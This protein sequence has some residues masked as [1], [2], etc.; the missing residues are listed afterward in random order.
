MRSRLRKGFAVV[1]IIAV[2]LTLLAISLAAPVLSTSE[3]FS[4]FNSGWNGTSHLAITTYESGKFAPSFTIRST[5]TDLSVEQVALDRLALVPTT[6]S[7]IIIGPK[8]AFAASEGKA[9]G[10]FVRGGGVL[11]LADDFGSANSLLEGMNASSRFSH[12]LVIDLAYEKQPEFSVCFDFE[13]DTLTTNVTTL[14]MNYPS[15]LVLNSSAQ[16]LARS[17]LAS[18]RDTNGDRLQEWGEPRGPFPLL[19][20]ERLGSGTI[21]LLSDPSVL[22]NGMGKY[23]NN[24]LFGSNLMD[25]VCEDRSSVYFD[26]SHRDFFDPV[27]VTFE[28]TGQVSTPVKIAIVILM[29]ACALWISSDMIDRLV[30]WAWIK[31]KSLVY[32]LLRPFSLLFSRK[33]PSAPPL[34]QETLVK[35]IT[36]EH[37][38][39]RPGL[40]RYL[41]RE[42]GRHRDALQKARE[43]SGDNK[44]YP[45]QDHDHEEHKPSVDEDVHALS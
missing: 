41:I 9:V 7:L 29:F 36:E 14:L 3:D 16:V 37:D 10:D 22:I 26:E 38:D 45:A 2:S 40:V 18:W 11:L 39:W 31:G 33:V 30:S 42:S 44:P 12:D 27:A 5:G 25:Y 35:K 21:I 34:D 4:I 8:K 24:S 43:E 23:L 28:F 15:S 20:K 19:A 32:T 17:S 13:P 1:A 6:D